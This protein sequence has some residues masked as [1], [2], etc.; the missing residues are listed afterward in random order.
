MK[1]G[2]T[3]RV[4]RPTDRLDDVVRFYR[5]GLGLEIIA[6]FDQHDG[7]DGRMLGHPQAPWHLEFTQH[8]DHAAGSA[9]T[10]DNL[11]VFYLPDRAEWEAAVQR[12]RD[13]GYAPVPSFNPYWDREGITFED[14]DGYRVV[15]QNMDW[16]K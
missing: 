16:V 11:L 9:P 1:K 4:A 15:L 6:A 2:T 3:L 10:Q 14:P 13:N 8:R 12:M 5:D 7:F